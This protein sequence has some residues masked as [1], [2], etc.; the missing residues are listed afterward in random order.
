MEFFWNDCDDPKYFHVLDTDTREITPVRNPITIYEKV[1]Y[2]DSTPNDVKN[3]KGNNVH[4]TPDNINPEQFKNKFVKVYVIH[5][6][7]PVMF[8]K[9]ID[10]LQDT[11]LHELKIAE[12]FDEFVGSAVEDENVRLETTSGLLS[13]YIDEVNTELD[14]DKLKDMVYG[15]MIEAENQ[16]LS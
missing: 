3:T 13:T 9:F 4:N 12:N 6:S 8:D 14:K 2:D 11:E 1:Y 10:K 15:L 7:D 16:D 5:K